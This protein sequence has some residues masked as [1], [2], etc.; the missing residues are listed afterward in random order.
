M[1][2]IQYIDELI[3]EYLLFRGFAGTL[4]MF[5]IELKQDK[6]K[7]FRVDR[8]VDQFLQ[9]IYAHDLTAVREFWSHLHTRMFSKLEKEFTSSLKKLE[10]G[11]LKLFLVNAICNNKSDKVTEFLSKMAPEL[12]HQP[13]WSEW[14][15][16]PF[17]KNPEENTLFS[18]YFSRQWQD[19]LLISLH[20]FL[21]CVY[22]V[23]PQPVLCSYEEE[24]TR[25][26]RLTEEN[27]VLRARLNLS[28]AQGQT[29]S[30]QAPMD[31]MDDF[32]NIA[33][34][35]PTTNESQVKSLKNLI[36]SIGG[37]GQPSNPILNSTG[38][39]TF[40]S[41]SD[42]KPVSKQRQSSTPSH[43]M[44]MASPSAEEKVPH[45]GVAKRSA[46][47]E[48][49]KLRDSS[50]SH[51]SP[52]S[53]SKSSSSQSFLVLSQENFTEHK[54][55]VTQVKF[56][57][58]GTHVASGD[59]EGY[60]KIWT[61]SP[62]PKGVCSVRVSNA[63][64][65]CI[66]WVKKNERYLMVGTGKGSVHLIDGKDARVHWESNPSIVNST[67]NRVVCLACNP[68]G[69][70]F[71]CSVVSNSKPNT[72]ALL[73][74][75]IKTKKIEHITAVDSKTLIFC[76]TYN[77]SGHVVLAGGQD[78]SLY[79]I[80]VRQNQ[81]LTK[82]PLHDSPIT[83][84]RLHQDNVSVYTMSSSQIVR[85]SLNETDG[86]G[87]HWDVGLKSNVQ[88]VFCLNQ[89]GTHLLL[90]SNES[91]AGTIYKIKRSGM[92]QVL[93]LN[94]HKDK[95]TACDWRANQCGPCLISSQDGVICVSTLLTS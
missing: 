34:E 16:I 59:V 44:K 43:Q 87:C 78:G 8:I 35:T 17:I 63:E 91:K 55:A 72:G 6:E 33:Q 25:L 30:A 80:D 46:S 86:S 21:A 1:T 20:N 74:F 77:H 94:E 19:T 57:S 28:L 95:L 81:V 93:S 69:S 14:F 75:E 23:L 49:R 40:Y 36:K 60:L 67:D 48:G 92:E 90:I 62:V 32:Y 47:V 11:V 27:E 79:K 31:L 3:R 7:G 45:L 42:N 2:H 10:N 53:S 73:R 61:P 22:Q 37:G 52:S 65:S 50:L 54:C 39:S 84:L 41:V 12:Q 66:D 38:N 70:T 4:K 64:I 26:R 15:L 51:A 58:S 29:P 71:T 13:E 18:L 24:V 9:L 82:I 56:N 76:L 89:A 88:H 5:D 83:S 68:V 85:S